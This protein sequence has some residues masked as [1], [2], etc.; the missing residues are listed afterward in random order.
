MPG[1]GQIYNGDAARGITY[2]ALFG[3][4]AA[5]AITSAVLGK[6]AADEY[7]E[8][9]PDTV[10]RRDDANAHFERTN[11][12]LA[13]LGAVWL[14]SVVDAYV[15]GVDAETINIDLAPAAGGGATAGISGAF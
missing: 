1:W 12:M 8:N 13:G 5:G 15:T 10:D 4:L 9:R 7:N 2:M 3:G 14:V 6:T 11:W